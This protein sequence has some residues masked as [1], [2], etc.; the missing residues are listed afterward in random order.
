MDFPVSADG[1]IDF[2][3]V[4][5]QFSTSSATL[6]SDNV[7]DFSQSWNEEQKSE[8]H[9]PNAKLLPASYKSQEIDLQRI[10]GK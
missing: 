1:D 4:C 3:Q 10:P 6:V 7:V 5:I 8:N 9:S 2:L